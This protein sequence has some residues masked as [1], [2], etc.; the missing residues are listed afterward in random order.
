MVIYCSTNV[1]FFAHFDL[2]ITTN[3]FS[4]LF[5]PLQMQF[6]ATLIFFIHIF[7]FLQYHFPSQWAGL[8]R[9]FWKYLFSIFT[10]AIQIVNPKGPEI[11]Q[12]YGLIQFKATYSDYEFDFGSI[13]N[14]AQLCETSW[15]FNEKENSVH[16]RSF[17]KMRCSQD[18][19]NCIWW[20]WPLFNSHYLRLCAQKSEMQFFS[21]YL[22]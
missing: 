19:E 1:L 16:W 13:S 12:Y 22:P 8:S 18:P 5:L 7:I 21:L 10:V 17:T 9:L 3:E 20:W 14:A 11:T 2:F 4:Q 15:N 6:F